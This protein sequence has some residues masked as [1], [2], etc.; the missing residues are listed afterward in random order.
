MKETSNAIYSSLKQ[1]EGIIVVLF[2]GFV[3]RS[4]L[5]PWRSYWY[6]ELLSVFY[7]G[8]YHETVLAAL[9]FLAENSVHPPLYQFV[10]YNWMH[11]FGD[12]ELATR[13]LSNVYIVGATLFL[14]LLAY[15]VFGRRVAFGSALLFTLMYFPMR[16]GIEARSYAQTLFLACLSSWLLFLF[17]TKLPKPC[18]L[19]E[20]VVNR[21]FVWLM[22]ANTGLITTHYYN[23]FF[24]G[25]QGL[26]FLVYVLTRRPRFGPIVEIG[27][28]AVV[29]LTPVAMLLLIWGSAMAHRY[30]KSETK[31]GYYTSFPSADPWTIFVDYVLTPTFQ[32]TSFSK[33]VPF[34]AAAALLA[35]SLQLAWNAYCWGRRGASERDCFAL[36]FLI[37]A[38]VP[39]LMAFL[40]FV[41][42]HAERYNARYFIFCSPPLAVI[43]VIALEG[44]VRFIDRGAWR[45]EGIKPARHYVRYALIYAIV[46]TMVIS[47][48]GGWR[49]AS[50]VKEDYRGIAKMVVNVISG[51]RE[52]TYIVYEASRGLDFYLTR[53]SS[54]GTRVSNYISRS[55]E[56]AGR[57]AFEKH[58]DEIRKHDFLIVA[59]THRRF[60]RFPKSAKRL[61]ELYDM[62][63]K[64]LDRNGKGIVVYSVGK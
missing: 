30:S 27:K 42:A 21:R 38:F 35:L 17:V 14:Y 1:H 2:L 5:A 50:T 26:F 16:Y 55:D 43:V 58:A 60:E 54:G 41:V 45:F 56:S 59:F 3:M 47:V 25:A 18:G 46:A 24:L 57:Y 34:A 11:F 6:D 29:S 44:V 23:V 32:G 12:S 31:G 63:F 36:Y 61:R 53:I 8:T 51:D 4:Y 15:R 13:S 64:L 20:L 33:W 62:H 22:L 52:H 19:K 49:A 9:Q 7:Y 39:C 10:L 37:W 48:P 40:L 28:I